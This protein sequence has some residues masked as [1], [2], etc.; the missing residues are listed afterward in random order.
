MHVHP[1][2]IV[3]A[4]GYSGLELTRILARHPRL[5]L[6]AL[7]SDRWSGE[8]AGA[9]LPVS[10]PAAALP[11]LPL[12]DAERVDAELV[13]L[14]TPA[15]VSAELAP[16]LVARGRVVVDLSGAFRLADAAVY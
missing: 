9:R 3:G 16:K 15:E 14:A 8:T 10:G 11:Y 13:Y 4:S 5:R 6:A 1:A 2:A 7:Y 12:A